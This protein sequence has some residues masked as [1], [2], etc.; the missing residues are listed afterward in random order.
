MSEAQSA[1]NGGADLVTLVCQEWP[2]LSRDKVAQVAQDRDR[3]VGFVAET[4]QHTRAL[5]SRQLD[6]LTS[7]AD[8]HG[9]AE[10]KL[11]A[12]LHKW[13]NRAEELLGTSR[14]ELTRNARETVER[15]V[16]MSLGV[17]ALVGIIMGFLLRGGGRDR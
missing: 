15:N 10:R 3:L 4:T 8:G 11:T 12:L 17:A 6:E 13:E 14:A 2:E 16:W 5:V 7:V 9:S 1:L